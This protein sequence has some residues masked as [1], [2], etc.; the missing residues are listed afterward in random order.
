MVPSNARLFAVFL[1]AWFAWDSA[2]VIPVYG[3]LLTFMAWWF[4]WA[5]S[6]MTLR[7]KLQ[8]ATWSEPSEGCIHAKMTFDAT[9]VMEYIEEKRRKTGEH[10]TLTHVVG[11][12]MGLILK[13]ATGL[14]GRIVFD[15]FVEHKTADVSFLA[16]LDEGK[17]LAKVKVNQ[18]DTKSLEQIAKELSAGANKLRKGTDENFKKSMGPVRI[19][20]TWIIRVILTVVG[21]AAGAL[22]ATIPSLGV[23]AYPFG[24]CLITSVGM[25]GVDEAFAPFTPFTRVSILILIGALFDGIVIEDGQI[26]IRKKVKLTATIDHRFLDGAQGGVMAKVMKKVFDNP[27]ELLD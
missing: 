2:Y 4:I 16:V 11:K 24:S 23:E 18:I 19:L 17:N 6:G 21:Y 10:I 7:R 9:K 12:A 13:E 3:V 8:I 15:R 26:Q 25:L 20:P 27:A 5:S 22:G 14:N 1:I